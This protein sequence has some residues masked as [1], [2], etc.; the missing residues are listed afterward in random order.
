MNPM[1][2][3]AG[4]HFVTP[5]LKISDGSPVQL[6]LPADA[7]AHAPEWRPIPEDPTPSVVT[8]NSDGSSQT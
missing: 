1:M 3:D 2:D 5:R 4:T 8:D 6:W 7:T